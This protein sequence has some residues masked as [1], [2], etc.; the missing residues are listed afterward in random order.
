MKTNIKN[1]TTRLK[2]GDKLEIAIGHEF[3]N[4]YW[5]KHSK[6]VYAV[7]SFRKGQIEFV[8]TAHH[9]EHFVLDN[10]YL[11]SGYA[12]ISSLIPMQP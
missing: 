11:K 8:N 4:E 10:R 9:T 5:H 12:F 1:L 6:T 3:K 7:H 2:V